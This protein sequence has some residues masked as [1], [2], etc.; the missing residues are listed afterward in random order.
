MVWVWKTEPNTKSCNFPLQKKKKNKQ[1]K[2]EAKD[3]QVWKT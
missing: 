1:N 2:Q 3:E